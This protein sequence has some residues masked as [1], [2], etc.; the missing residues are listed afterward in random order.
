M[1]SWTGCTCSLLN[2]AVFCCAVSDAVASAC[3]GANKW[4]LEQAIDGESSAAQTEAEALRAASQTQ[5]AI[6]LATH[7]HSLAHSL[8]ACCLSDYYSNKN[9]YSS[10][11]AAAGSSSSS[12]V[13][14]KKLTAIF[15]QVSSKL[16]V[17]YQ[18]LTG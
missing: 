3:L 13:D 16:A 7:W 2:R 12:K 9:K 6:A 1:L 8:C 17:F 18:L 15:N 10:G 14:A 5:R 4:N 11:A